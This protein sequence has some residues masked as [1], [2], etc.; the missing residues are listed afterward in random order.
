MLQ[1][2]DGIWSTLTESPE[3][4]NGESLEI[5]CDFLWSVNLEERIAKKPLCSKEELL[6]QILQRNKLK[7]KW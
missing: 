6:M 5:L 3:E 1:L 2:I 4:C 7:Y